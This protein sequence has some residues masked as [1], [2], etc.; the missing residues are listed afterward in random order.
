MGSTRILDW[1]RCDLCDHLTWPLG[2]CI[3]CESERRQHRELYATRAVSKACL[4]I[5]FPHLAHDELA[6][7]VLK[8]YLR[9]PLFPCWFRAFLRHHLLPH[10]LDTRNSFH[11]L[12]YFYNGM[13]GSVDERTD[14]LDV[15]LSF[16]I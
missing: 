13:A 12:T 5:I 8:E 16:V 7:A 1:P 15:V 10:G 4:R 3:R 11:R 6:R 2:L 9:V 14:I